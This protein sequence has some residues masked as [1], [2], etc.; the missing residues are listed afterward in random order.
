MSLTGKIVAALVLLTALA[1]A[2]AWAVHIIHKA[3]ERD[4]AVARVAQV[5]REKVDLAKTFATAQAA[6]VTIAAELAELRAQRAADSLEFRGL[7][8]RKPLVTQVP[9]E[10]NGQ[11]FTCPERDAHRY[12]CLHNRAVNGKAD[13]D[14]LL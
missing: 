10:S 13:P 5:E 14:C 7:L 6:D 12:R 2:G 4:A 9:H 3:S 8:T 1:G 11:T